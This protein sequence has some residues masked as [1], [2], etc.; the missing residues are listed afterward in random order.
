MGVAASV[1]QAFQGAVIA[2]LIF[3]RPLFGLPYSESLFLLL[4][5]ALNTPASVDG[6]TLP[7]L[8]CPCREPPSWLWCD[9]LILPLGSL[10][11]IPFCYL[12]VVHQQNATVMSSSLTFV[13]LSNI[14]YSEAQ[15]PL[16]WGQPVQ[17]THG[18]GVAATLVGS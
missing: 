16:F 2:F 14:L 6:C 5:V 9:K 1:F 4:Y 7:V 15:E 18:A 10:F 3:S 17:R 11:S 8:S 12:C 13:G